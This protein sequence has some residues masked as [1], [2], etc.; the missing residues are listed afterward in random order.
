VLATTV[1]CSSHCAVVPV[2]KQIRLQRLSE[3]AVW[4]VQ[5]SDV[6]WQT[7][8]QS[9]SHDA[10]SSVSRGWHVQA[11]HATLNKD[12]INANTKAATYCVCQSPTLFL[13]PVLG[14]MNTEAVVIFKT[15]DTK[16]VC[17]MAWALSAKAFSVSAPSVWNSLSLDY[18]LSPA[19]SNAC[20]RLNSSLLLNLCISI[21]GVTMMSFHWQQLLSPSCRE[22]VWSHFKVVNWSMP[23]KCYAWK[24]SLRFANSC[25]IYISA[26]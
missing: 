22:S 2:P 15:L 17:T 5:L 13:E 4:Q 25:Y 16:A 20:S 10:K 18:R 7:V 8:P 12:S 21:H 19:H 3:S 24:T 23:T 6:G 14:L 1:K 9:L 26:F 11:Y